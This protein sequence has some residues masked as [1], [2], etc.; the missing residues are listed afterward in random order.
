MFFDENDSKDALQAKHAAQLIAFAPV[1]FQVA[2]CMRDFGILELLYKHSENGLS[3]DE[4]CEQIDLS[5]YAIK[6]LLESSLS[7]DIVKVKNDRYKITKTG[8]YLFKDSLTKVNLDYI[9]HV[10]Y[11]GLFY[12]D[13]ALKNEEPTGLKKCFGEHET[14]YPLLS[15]LPEQVKKSWFEFDHYY[16]DTAFKKAIDILLNLKPKKVLDIGGNTGKF[17]MELAKADENVHISICDL[18][19]QIELSKQNIAK[20]NLSSQIDFYPIDILQDDCKLPSGYDIIWMS[21]FLDCFK[22]EDIIKILKNVKKSKS[23]ESK[24]FIVEPLWDKQKFETS[25]FCIINT[26][27]Y[28]TAM[29]NG[30]SKMFNYKDLKSYIAQ[31][32]LEIVDEHHEVGICQSVL[33]CK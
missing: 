6:V 24:I 23:S 20:N 29:A 18:K 11:N 13:D 8:Y 3:L 26:S 33:I 1:V 31:A 17:A 27:P 5:K 4:I 15:S 16:S 21:Q 9:H 10:N 32:G 14:I 28:F 25:A 12:L 30:Y 7:S 22:E 2:R 19:E